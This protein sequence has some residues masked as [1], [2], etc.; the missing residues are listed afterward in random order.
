M[1]L[2]RDRSG[3][4]LFERDA[5]VVQRHLV[6]VDV[7]IP[8]AHHRDE[9]WRE[10]DH[11]TQ[12]ALALS[13]RVCELLLFGDVHRRTQQPGVGWNTNAADDPGLSVGPDDT[14]R[15]IEL[16]RILRE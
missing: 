5:E 11:L 15:E 16:L 13:Q 10:V 6:G 7:F 2:V 9:L 3:S 4:A 12:L 1:N 8:L 14:L